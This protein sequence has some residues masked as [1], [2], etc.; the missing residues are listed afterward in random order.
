[1]PYLGYNIQHF[2]VF[3]PFVN[4]PAIPALRLVEAQSSVVHHRQR[5]PENYGKMF[6]LRSLHSLPP[7]LLLFFLS[8]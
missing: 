2:V 4:I 1:M 3:A 8:H 5:K 7:L 6:V